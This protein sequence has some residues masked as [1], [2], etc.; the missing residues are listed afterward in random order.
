MDLGRER[1]APHHQNQPSGSVLSWRPR[2]RPGT[3]GALSVPWRHPQPSA[4][5]FRSGYHLEVTNLVWMAQV[6]WGFGYADQAHQR[7]QEALAVAVCGGAGGPV[8][9]LQQ[10]LT[11]FLAEEDASVEA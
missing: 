1:Q 6:L 8:A 10:R 9:R 4:P 3:P 5:T 2:G 7:G 11:A